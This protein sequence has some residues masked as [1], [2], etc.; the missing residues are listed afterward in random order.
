MGLLHDNDDFIWLNLNNIVFQEKAHLQKDDDV[1]EH[2]DFSVDKL[3]KGEQVV[4]FAVIIDA[5][6]LTAMLQEK[7]L[8]IQSK[9]LLEQEPHL[10]LAEKTRY[11]SISEREQ[12]YIYTVVWSHK[13]CCTSL[14]NKQ[15]DI[16]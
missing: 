7:T 11:T 14:G 16:N 8:D 1:D 2:I 9:L 6:L 13:L 12:V 10:Q 5:V 3:A 15:S 4:C